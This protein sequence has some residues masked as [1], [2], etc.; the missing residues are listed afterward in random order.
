LREKYGVNQTQLSIA[1]TISR[2]G[3]TC[4]LVGVRNPQQAADVAPG[5]NIELSAEDLAAMDTIIAAMA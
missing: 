4:A 5:G 2:P 1:W 3:V